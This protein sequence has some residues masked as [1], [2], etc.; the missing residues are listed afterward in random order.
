LDHKRRSFDELD[1]EGVLRFPV[2]NRVSSSSGAQI[3]S[4]ESVQRRRRPLFNDCLVERA[5]VDAFVEIFYN[6]VQ[7]IIRVGLKSDVV[8]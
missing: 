8:E 3:N 6:S 2:G 7:H 4:A 5:A 1:L